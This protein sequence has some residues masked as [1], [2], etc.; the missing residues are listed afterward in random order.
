M[1]QPKYNPQQ[2]IDRIRLMMN[3]N[4]SKTL[5]ENKEIVS[6]IDKS[7]DTDFLFDFVISE[8]N[9]ILIYMDSVFSAKHGFIGNLWENT[10]VFNEIIRENINNYSS[11]IGESV[12][13]DLDSILM[14]INWTKEF[15]AECILGVGTLSEGFS[16]NEQFLD[17]LKAGAKRIKKG[18]DATGRAIAKGTRQVISKAAEYGKKLLAGPIL[19]TLRWIRRNIYTNVGM[20]VDIVTSMLPATTGINKIVWGMIVFLDMYEILSSD[21]DKQDPQRNQMPYLFLTI[22]L[23]SAIFT[24]GAGTIF[25]TATKP[26]TTVGKKTAVKLPSQVTTILKKLLDYL[27]N[28]RGFMQ[29]ISKFLEKNLPTIKSILDFVFKGIDT[30]IKGIEDFISQLFSKTGAKA[31]GAA[32]LFAALFHQR[33]LKLGDSGKDAE[34]VNMFLMEFNSI[35]RFTFDKNPNCKPID[36]TIL[37]GLKSSGDKF[38]EY[39]ESAVKT[40][41]ACYV[42]L[43]PYNE[44]FKKVDGMVSDGEIAAYA[45]GA[46]VNDRNIITKWIPHTVKEKSA[47]AVTS[48]ITYIAGKVEGAFKFAGVNKVEGPITK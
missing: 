23:I 45:E 39:T 32:T 27:P 36:E 14:S 9:G 41:E 31:V 10:W 47:M 21:Y 18:I 33:P 48:A 44:L 42:S 5:S 30:I 17:K 28:V 43:S 7:N 24:V 15:V 12:E 2:S 29:S 38:T 26:L 40:L 1:V 37:N 11:L 6:I 35:E 46:Q 4:I 22:D 25:R 16:I 3:Y 13:K 34:A 8:S 19:G 20:V